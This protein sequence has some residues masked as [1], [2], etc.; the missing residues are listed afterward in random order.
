[1]PP[2]SC[3]NQPGLPRGRFRSQWPPRL[4]LN[5]RF[6]P[7]PVPDAH[8]PPSL[9]ASTH[10][11]DAGNAGRRPRPAPSATTSLVCAL[12]PMPH[13]TILHFVLRCT[14]YTLL[15]STALHSLAS[16]HSAPLHTVCLH[17]NCTGQMQH[18]AHVSFLINTTWLCLTDASPRAML[19]GFSIGFHSASGVGA[20]H[21]KPHALSTAASHVSWFD[22]RRHA[23]IS[24]ASGA[25]SRAH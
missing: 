23:L 16:L 20:R 25:P 5:V 24:A 10:Q 18:G 1:M 6:A 15:V 17:M 13:V 9:R 2:A 4:H 8:L 7:A 12:R 22:R 21:R 11:P 3:L 14:V 19:A